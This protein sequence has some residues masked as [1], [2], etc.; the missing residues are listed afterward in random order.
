MHSLIAESGQLHLGLTLDTGATFASFYVESNELAV[1]LLQSMATPQGEPQLLLHGA[2]GSGKTHL[3]HAYCQIL[4][5]AGRRVAYLPLRELCDRDPDAVLPG[6]ETL[7][8]VCIDELDVV[9]SEAHWETALFDL[10]NR[11]RESGARLLLAAQCNPVHEHTVMPDL[12]SRFG[13]GPVVQL[14]L[15]RDEPLERALRHRADALGLTLADASVAYIRTRGPRLTSELFRFL[16]QLDE[17]SLAE[18]RAL[19]VPFIRRLLA[20]GALDGREADN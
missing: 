5:N 12:A 4:A 10:L 1:Q 19:T 15:L 16:A 11:L 7:H 13:W 6:L 2:S 17:A 20:R 9:L 14:R 8:S 18:Q 3:M